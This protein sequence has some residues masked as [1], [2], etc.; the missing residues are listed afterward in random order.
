MPGVLV[1]GVPCRLR[2]YNL[3]FIDNPVGTG[4]SFTKKDA[5]YATNQTDVA[6]DLYSALQQFLTL[7]P[8]LR[9]N[10]FYVTGESYA[11]KQYYIRVLCNLFSVY[12]SWYILAQASTS[13]QYH[14]RST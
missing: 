7:F 9:N 4:F 12:N 14:T 5:G 6:R 1:F 2:R 10:D 13:R 3:L 8:D 11:G